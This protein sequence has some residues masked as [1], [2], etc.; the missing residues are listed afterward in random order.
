MTAQ[1]S[2]GERIARSLPGASFELETLV[3]LVG[4]HE[5][6]TIPSAAVTCGDRTRLLVNPTFVERFCRS[7]EHLF[8]LVMHEMWHVLLGHTT[9]YGRPTQ[10]HN[11]AFDALIN[12][13]LA[14]QH[15]QAQY[16]GFFEELNR[17]DIFPQ[18]LLRPPVGWPNKPN[19]QTSG[20]RGTEEILRRLY[21]PAGH[22]TTEPTYQELLDLLNSHVGP[23]EGN[24]IGDHETGQPDPL[25]DPV[26]LDAVRRVVENW[27]PP[28]E[29]MR[30]R[31]SGRE[32]SPHW[33]QPE[34]QHRPQREELKKIL[35]EVTRPNREGER[36][37]RRIPTIMTVGPGP[38]P[39][40]KDRLQHAKRILGSGLVLPSQ[41]I[42]VAVRSPEPPEQALVYLDVSGSMVALLPHLVGL[43][44]GPAKRRLV[45]VKQFST[46][47]E[48]LSAEEL[49]QGALKTTS[50]T[51]IDC[52]LR[53]AA[54]RKERVILLITDGYV[55]PANP[56][57]LTDLVQRGVRI[58]AALPEDGWHRDLQ[59]YATIHKLTNPEQRSHT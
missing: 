54:R 20:P 52:V 55:G 45:T 51:D 59:P 47:V 35:R 10:A 26:F 40:A 33:V 16:R 34:T 6:E 1:G 49:A 58:H 28:P 23:M 21:P 56:V 2:I 38:L 37:R 24:L 25:A 14:R 13:G 32:L 42:A 53:D 44:A 43:L 11:M 22:T 4:V 15:P 41:T 31:D 18:L 27:P 39:N 36:Q 5:T 50:G 12:A 19:Y 7:D 46:A 57:L 3:R 29:L 30:G 17:H 8:L 9:L 48:P